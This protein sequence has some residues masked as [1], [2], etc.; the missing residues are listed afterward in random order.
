MENDLN[1]LIRYRNYAEELRLIAGERGNPR[2]FEALQRIAADYERMAISLE[3]MIK[4]RSFIN[5]PPQNGGET[6]ISS[7]SEKRT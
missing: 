4:A 1:R 6:R 5:Q 2:D 7:D 3:G